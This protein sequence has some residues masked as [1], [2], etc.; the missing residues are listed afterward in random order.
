MLRAVLL[1]INREIKELK[2]IL[3]E[4]FRLLNMT[5]EMYTYMYIQVL[6]IQKLISSRTC[7]SSLSVCLSF[8]RYS[9]KPSLVNSYCRWTLKFMSSTEWTTIFTNCIQATMNSMWKLSYWV[10]YAISVVNRRRSKQTSLKLSNAD[11]MISWPPFTRQ[12]AARSSSTRAFVLKTVYVCMYV[13]IY[14]FFH[15]IWKA[16][17][18][19]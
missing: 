7:K 10:K 3:Y 14:F 1:Y 18:T 2:K 4:I 8:S 16:L 17:L 5:A 9:S 19:R 13:Y 6:W 15:R 12:M 11:K